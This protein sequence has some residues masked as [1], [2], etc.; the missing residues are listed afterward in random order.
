MTSQRFSF[1]FLCF[2]GRQKFEFACC[3]NDWL[4]PIKLDCLLDSITECG[5]PPIGKQVRDEVRAGW[6]VGRDRGSVNRDA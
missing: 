5:R 1:V 4:L 2:V 3:A 6:N